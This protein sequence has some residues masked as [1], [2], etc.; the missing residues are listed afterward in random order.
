[1]T[2]VLI[3]LA[4]TLYLV[5]GLMAAAGG[6]ITAFTMSAASKLSPDVLRRAGMTSEQ[7]AVVKNFP[8]KHF[9]SLIIVSL[10][11]IPAWPGIAL[12]TRIRRWLAK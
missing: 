6:L 9:R 11:A 5:V 3:V 7:I 10:I 1:M 12:V 4:I 2:N 8:E